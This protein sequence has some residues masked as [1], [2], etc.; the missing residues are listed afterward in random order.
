[1]KTLFKETTCLWLSALLLLS[2]VL[3]SKCP[4]AG[5]T[6][7]THGLNGNTDDW[8][9]AMVGKMGEHPKLPGTNS[10]CYEIY[11]AN[12]AGSYFV[13]QR[14]V[15]GVP[16]TNNHSGE[17]FIRLDW[18]QLANDSYSTYQVAVPVATALLSTNFIPELG[19]RA[20]AE[21]PLHLVGHSRG[22]SLMCEIS[23]LLGENG[24]WV[25]HLTTLD[26][27]PLNNDGFFDFPYSVVDAP[28][29]VYRNV[30]FADNYW[31][32]LNLFTPGE[33]LPGAFN[34]KLLYLDG[35][36]EGLTASHSDAHLWY[37][38][39]IDLGTPASDSVASV[40]QFERNNWWTFA[41]ASGATVG[42]KYSRMVGGDRFSSFA[43][44]GD[45]A[46]RD[47]V[48]QIWN[49][50]A[51]SS[52]NRTS[53][54][55]NAGLW[56]NPIRFFLTSTNRLTVG[57]NFS[58]TLY[59][60]SAPANNT[61]VAVQFYLDPDGNP[62]NNNAVLVSQGTATTTGP[63]I[64]ANF[65]VSLPTSLTNTPAGDYRLLVKMTYG[66][67]S[68]F[69]YGDQVVSVF[70]QAGPSLSLIPPFSHPYG[71]RISSMPGVKV[72]LQ[73]STNL[74]SW[75]SIGTNTLS[76]A[77]WDAVDSTSAGSSRRFYRALVVP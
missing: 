9:A 64:V 57:E 47:G 5:V 44:A 24:V 23:R 61:T 68:R 39:T 60:Q 14:R 33:S 46:P 67:K 31:Q 52:F 20:L 7:V 62:L 77:S 59:H 54:T 16:A 56:P 43:P 22:G 28:A 13:T 51:G 75:N 74:S 10:S 58:V 66:G 26:P 19:G 40:T 18:R 72:V 27:H 6:I 73:W 76:T 4:A 70:S 55:N 21:F 42:Y 12:V 17:I 69:T 45:A 71:V 1:M 37:H 36:Y 25:D 35:G 41:E 48:N 32:D 34:R 38:G 50:G 2:A 3:S 53:L 15:S 30:L 65:S 49:F 63:S 11:F 29:R 8:V